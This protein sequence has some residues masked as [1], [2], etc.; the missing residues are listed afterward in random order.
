MILYPNAKINIGLHVI[1][2][3]SD[4]FHDIETEFY[5]VSAL[6][7]VLEIVPSDKLEM[8]QYGIVY[9]GDPMDN[10][11]I[12]AYRRLSEYISARDGKPLPPVTVSLHK[13]IPVG[14]GLG[15]GSSDAAFVIR[16]LDELFS[17]SLSVQ[18]MESVAAKVGS[19]CPFFI[20]NRPAYAVG[21]GTEL[22]PYSSEVIDH[23]ERD[24]QVRFIHPE[25]F[26]STKEAYSGM[27]PRNVSGFSTPPLKEMLA[28]PPD[29]WK[30][31]VVN[32]FEPH[33]FEKYP[34]IAEAVD[35]LYRQGAVYASMTGS[36][37]TV[38]GIFRL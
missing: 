35:E 22:S 12:K 10:L 33:I 16:G 2:K 24:Y 26:V 17:L 11:C 36:G 14:A 18:E 5:P 20:S 7:D 13:R 9:D 30:G 32:D 37:S 8:N 31:K 25:V 4:G 23:L 3:R 6:Y 1:R 15:G 21:R 27:V 28:L 19:D 34:A 29:R 38:Y